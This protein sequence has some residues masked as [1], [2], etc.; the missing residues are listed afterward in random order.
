MIQS[1]FN[2][3]IT[4]FSAIMCLPLLWGISLYYILKRKPKKIN[5]EEMIRRI[6]NEMRDM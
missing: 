6:K 1:F 5:K 4:V 2:F 3:V